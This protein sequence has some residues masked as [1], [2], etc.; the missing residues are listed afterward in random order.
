MQGKPLARLLTLVLESDVVWD[1]KD[2]NVRLST[3][4]LVEVGLS[5]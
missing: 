2:P 5:R 1:A 4:Q 3:M